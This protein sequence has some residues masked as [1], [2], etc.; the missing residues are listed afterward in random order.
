MPT[1]A[2]TW[3][4]AVAVIALAAAFAL[5]ACAAE[6]PKDAETEAPK[7]PASASAPA[8]STTPPEELITVAE[9]EKTSKIEGV[10]VVA[11]DA[12]PGATGDVNFANEA[13]GVFLVVTLGTSDQFDESKTGDTYGKAVSGIADEAYLGPKESLSKTPNKLVFRKG[14]DSVA[15]TTFFTAPD[16]TVLSIDQLEEIANIIAG[17]L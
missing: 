1:T 7:P 3:R 10:Q 9:V 13:G 15:L 4:L 12:K 8:T 6:E 2:R 14:N 11:R 16:K 17:R 5:S